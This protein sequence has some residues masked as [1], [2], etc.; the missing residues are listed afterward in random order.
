MGNINRT[1]AL[2]LIAVIAFSC[3]SLLSF[4]PANAQTI[5]KPSVP[6]FTLEYS[7][8]SYDVPPTYGLDPYTGKNIMTQAGYYVKN[9]SVEVTIKNQ[10]FTAYRNDNGSMVY[11]FYVVETKGHFEDWNPYYADASYWLRQNLSEMYPTNFVAA[12]NTQNTVV[13]YGL[14]GD[15]ATISSSYN[16]DYTYTLSNI[17]GE[18]KVDFRI[19]TIIGYST[20][21]NDTAVPGVPV[22]NPTDP[23]PRHY[24]FTG[25][26]SDWSNTET[27]SIPDGKVTTTE[28]TN[29]TALPTPTVPELPL[30]VLIPVVIVMLAV[31]LIL[32]HRKTANFG[33]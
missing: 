23:N 19:Q 26:Y 8:K 3:L 10:P 2:I 24:V 31:A 14:E 27:I 6:E 11:L 4:K 9:A 30:F 28:P 17:A 32:T 33:K 15:N 1:W 22:G 7:D 25:Q 18:G 16:G 12:S 13:T 5:P 20:R 21:Y 29:P